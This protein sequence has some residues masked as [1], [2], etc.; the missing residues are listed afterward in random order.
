M[1]GALL[2]F[3]PMVL[4]YRFHQEFATGAGGRGAQVAVGVAVILR[5]TLRRLLR[6][7]T[8]N[9]LR[10]SLG[11]FSRTSARTMTRRVARMSTRYVLG[12]LTVRSVTSRDDEPES[13][14]RVAALN[15]ASFLIGALAL[16][17]SFAYVVSQL[18]TADAQA[19][20]SSTGLGDDSVVMLSALAALPLVLYVAAAYVVAR[21]FGSQLR[22]RTAVD[23]LLLQ[24]YF[25][26]ANSF[27]PM[28]T[29]IEVSGDKRTQFK[30]SIGIL[31]LLYL[32]HLVLYWTSI[33]SDSQTGSTLAAFVLIYCFVYSFPIAPLQGYWIWKHNRI[34]WLVVWLPILVSFVITMPAELASLL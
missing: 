5:T 22:V 1:L 25:A 14:V 9:L 33:V 32:V 7:G 27:L 23:G 11:A 24:A 3:L 12:L 16:A 31:V 19:L 2:L 30:A 21:C 34:V 18:S 17:L 15:G 4:V 13:A 20:A 8:T 28:T 29:D 10:T 6:A 26:G